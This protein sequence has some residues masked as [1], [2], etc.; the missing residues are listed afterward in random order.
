MESQNECVCA[1][2]YFHFNFL[3]LTA[4]ITDLSIVHPFMRHTMSQ[5]LLFSEM[6]RSVENKIR[7]F[8]SIYVCVCAVQLMLLPKWFVNVGSTF[9]LSSALPESSLI[10]RYI[11]LL[12]IWPSQSLAKTCFFSV[13]VACV[14]NRY[15][16]DFYWI[17]SCVNGSTFVGDAMR[18][19]AC[20][21]IFHL[22]LSLTNHSAGW[23]QSMPR[24]VKINLQIS[25]S[26][27]PIRCN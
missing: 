1:P 17:C 16:T 9:F 2:F 22:K 20:V 21:Q 6:L 24:H 26:E 8:V 27:T 25:S 5:R 23:Y 12:S 4:H 13:V 14:G 19:Y 18:I 7:H 10:H 15:Q 3:S 11:F